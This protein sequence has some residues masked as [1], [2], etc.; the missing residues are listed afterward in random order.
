MSAIAAIFKFILLAVVAVVALGATVIGVFAWSNANAGSA[1]AECE[2]RILEQKIQANKTN[3]YRRQCMRSKGYLMS[4]NCW[5]RG[6]TVSS[7]FH[8]R[9]IFWVNTVDF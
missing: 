4:A 7:C 6:Y 1:H 8:P 3:D 9:W 2:M 5:A